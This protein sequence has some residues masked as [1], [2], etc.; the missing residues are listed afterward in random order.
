[1]KRKRTYAVTVT[2]VVTDDESH[3]LTLQETRSII[4]E[5]MPEPEI[6]D[7]QNGWSIHGAGY[8]ALVTKVSLPKRA[9]RTT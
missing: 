2:V 4:R 3:P 7:Y 1:V 6:A 5:I 8:E 9:R